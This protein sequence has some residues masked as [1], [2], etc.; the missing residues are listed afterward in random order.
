MVTI[1]WYIPTTFIEVVFSIFTIVLTIVVFGY[2]VNTIGMILTNIDLK[3]K[4]LTHEIQ[5]VNR[6]LRKNKVDFELRQ[7]IQNYIC[8][9]HEGDS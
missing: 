5:F 6:Y 9:V 3:N 8:Y 1:V 7:K 2:S 4:R